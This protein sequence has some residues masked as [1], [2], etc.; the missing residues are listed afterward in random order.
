VRSRGKPETSAAGFTLVEMAVVLLIIAVIAALTVTTFSRAKPRADMK[1]A[2]A[3]LQALI[4][5]ARETA[6]S[7]GTPVAVLVYKAYT[8]PSSGTGYFIVYQDACFD[9]F[10]GGATCGV[11]YAAYNPAQLV[12]GASATTSSVVIDT[13]TL[14]NNVSIGPS[15][16][17]GTSA[18]LPAPLAGVAVNVDCSFCGSTGGAIQFDPSGQATFYALSGTTQTGPLGPSS[19]PAVNGGASVSLTYNSALTSDTGQ[20]TLVILSASGAVQVRGTG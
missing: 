11:T 2:A 6:L 17:M 9:F 18:T 7:T 4:H 8:P 16:G 19:T 13:M 10:T 5:Q 3:E 14:P 15:S 1:S 12:V 20:L